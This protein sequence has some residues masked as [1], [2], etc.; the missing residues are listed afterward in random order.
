[1]YKRKLGKTDLQIG[2]VGLGCWQFG[3]DFGPME[4]ETAFSIMNCAV[5]HGTTFFDTADVYGA[6]RSESLI[7]R[8]IKN[9]DTRITIATKFGRSADVYPDG[10]TK[11]KLKKAVEGSLQRLDVDSLDLLQLHCIPG[12]AL[13]DAK[14]FDW[15]RDIQTEGLIK[16]FG[17]SVES[18]EEALICLEH[19]D[20]STL[21]VIFNIFRQK[22]I[23]ELFPKS[24][25]K[26]VGIIV[27]LPVASGL[28]TGKFTSET[29]FVETDHRNFN[30]DGQYFNVG[31]TFAGL[32][33]EKGVEL[34]DILKEIIPEG[35]SL[36]QMA[37]R[38]ILDF[39]EV[40]VV[41]PGASSAAQAKENAIVSDL[42]PLSKELHDWLTEFYKLKVHDHIRGPY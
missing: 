5:E 3:G 18:V 35:M 16:N 12:H 36:A 20:L 8:F 15:L 30:R 19:E 27:R 4:E 37:L 23:S 41:I 22:L 2:E 13:R 7:G 33:F 29:R 39:D 31:E 38:W 14:I 6:G 1:M 32:P 9:S 17:A 10:Y 28:L 40:S 11:D 21:Q 34:A 25:E 42:N 26:N 24:K